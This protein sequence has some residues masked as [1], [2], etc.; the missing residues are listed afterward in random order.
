MRKGLMAV[1][2]SS[3]L[4]TAVAPAAAGADVSEAPWRAK[5]RAFAQTHFRHPAWGYSHSV[6]DYEL[7]RDLAA[8]DHA[9][10]DDD[11]LFAAAMLHDMAGFAPWEDE[12]RDHSDVACDTIIPV[13]KDAG[14]P[15]EKLAKV[16]SAIRTHMY[17]RK[18]LDP[19]ARYIH[20]ADGLDWLGAIGVARVMALADPKG[21]MP[22][23]PGVEKLL[24]SNLKDVPDTIVTPAGKA[25][26]PARRDALKAW[27]NALAAQTDGFRTL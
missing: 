7:A 17:Y 11:V 24:A 14:F 20:D 15:M 19:E 12:K 2:A 23:G 22:D 6:R 25:L 5:V 21:G 26:M 4:I 27:I 10:I 8:A 13:L 1:L 9:N 16:Q 18:P 3:F